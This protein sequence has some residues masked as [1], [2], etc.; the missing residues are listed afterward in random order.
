MAR[1]TRKLQDVYDTL[2][3]APRNQADL[4]AGEDAEGARLIAEQGYAV[5]LSRATGPRVVRSMED[6]QAVR[7]GKKFHADGRPIGLDPEPFFAALEAR[8]RAARIAQAK[9]APRPPPRPR[10]R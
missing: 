4:L 9:A 2:D 6:W 5:A 8:E 7:A 3:D 1:L 10:G